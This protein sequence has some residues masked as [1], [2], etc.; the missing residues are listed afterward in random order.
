MS[1]FVCARNA[2][3]ESPAIPPAAIARND[4]RARRLCTALD[5]FGKAFLIG[6]GVPQAISSSREPFVSHASTVIL[7]PDA[8]GALLDVPELR[9]CG[10]ELV[11]GRGDGPH[12]GEGALELGDV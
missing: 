12:R 3:G 9:G 4:E 2:T 5:D 6:T 10:V 1:G 7:P 11:A 8:L